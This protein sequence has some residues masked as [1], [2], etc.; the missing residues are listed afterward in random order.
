MYLCFPLMG[1]DIREVGTAASL[2]GE[3]GEIATELFKGFLLI[4][5][6]EILI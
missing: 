2:N 6:K 4:S 1:S 3:C 5:G